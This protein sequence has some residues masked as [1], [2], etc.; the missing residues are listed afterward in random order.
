MK[1]LKQTTYELMA[2]YHGPNMLGD[3][4]PLKRGPAVYQHDAS[5]EHNTL[6]PKSEEE[7]NEVYADIVGF[8]GLNSTSQIDLSGKSHYFA[9]LGALRGFNRG[10]EMHDKFVMPDNV[11][12]QFYTNPHEG[13]EF[14][15]II[16][17]TGKKP[18]Y[19]DTIITA[20]A[21][22]GQRESEA[23][24]IDSFAQAV[25]IYIPR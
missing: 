14:M 20:L 16:A 23:F 19:L 21:G 22:V 5:K 24:N 15:D 1:K 2:L 12:L 11:I 3:V 8:L 18:A 25:G 7:F 6:R 9:E 13:T 4:N 10:F 17:Q